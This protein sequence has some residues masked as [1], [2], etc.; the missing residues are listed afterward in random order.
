MTLTNRRFVPGSSTKC[1]SRA[2]SPLM[3]GIVAN[4]R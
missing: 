3:S 1:I 2:A 4:S